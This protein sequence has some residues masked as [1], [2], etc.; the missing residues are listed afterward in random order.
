MEPPGHPSPALPELA[1]SLCPKGAQVSANVRPFVLLN[2]P[3]VPVPAWGLKASSVL[4]AST[5]LGMVAQRHLC[6]HGQSRCPLPGHHKPSGDDGSHRHPACPSSCVER[7]LL[8]SP[9]PS[10]SAIVPWQCRFGPFLSSC[11]I[12][13]ALLPPPA[14]PALG[15]G[16]P[17][18]PQCCRK[19]SS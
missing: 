8:R 6:E 11:S 14:P 5:H 7:P 12:A 1:S 13:A 4:S 10:I 2:R 16:S 18:V 17:G 9:A 19:G 3:I 15:I